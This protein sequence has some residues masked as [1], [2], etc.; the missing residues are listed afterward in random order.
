MPLCFLQSN[1]QIAPVNKN[2]CSEFE[3]LL[4]TFVRDEEQS[5]RNAPLICVLLS[6]DTHL[7]RGVRVTCLLICIQIS[8]GFKLP[9]KAVREH[10]QL[11]TCRSGYCCSSEWSVTLGWTAVFFS[12]FTHF[13]FVI[14]SYSSEDTTYTMQTFLFRLVWAAGFSCRGSKQIKLKWK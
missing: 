9:H 14:H 4:L 8:Q 13:W 7:R 10:S 2:S 3:G 6:Q 12:V 5:L 11:H 1:S